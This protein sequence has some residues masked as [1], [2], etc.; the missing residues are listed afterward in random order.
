MM[1][2][3]ESASVVSL[4]GSMAG[5]IVILNFMARIRLKNNDSIIAYYDY[6]YRLS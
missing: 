6:D 4:R 1:A 3:K 2:D 5:L